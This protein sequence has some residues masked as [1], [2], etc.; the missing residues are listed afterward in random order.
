M[1]LKKAYDKIIGV[2][3]KLLTKF[4]IEENIS[5]FEFLFQNLN[6]KPNLALLGQSGA[7]KSTLLNKII[8]D[9]ILESS[10]GKG[11]VTQYP[12]E[13]KYGS[14]VNYD[15]IPNENIEKDQ[16]K[17]IFEDK[18]YCSTYSDDLL[19]DI[20]LLKK[21]YDFIEVIKGC[22]VPY[23]SKKNKYKW[24]EFNKKI[25]GNENKKYHFQYERE[26]NNIWINV[27]PF[28]NKLIIYIPRE[29]LKKVNLVDLPGSY[30]KSKLRTDKTNDYLENETDFIIIV[31]NNNRAMTSSFIDKSLNNHIA[32]I[33]VSKGIPDILLA[34]T[35]IDY[36]YD[37]IVK[38]YKG[39]QSDSD[40][41]LEDEIY[42][43]IKNELENRMT[44]TSDK[45]E[46]DIKN[47][48]SLEIH[49]IK[50]ENINI[51][52]CSSEKKINDSKNGIGMETIKILS[53]YII[54][55]CDRR[56]NR[57]EN[58]IKYLLD[59]YYTD[60]KNYVNKSNLENEEK[61]KI[62]KIIKN[63]NKEL[64]ESLILSSL[65]ISN[66]ITDTDFNKVIEYNEKYR[67][68]LNDNTHGITLTSVLKKMYH[69][70]IHGEIFNLVEDLSVEYKKEWYNI[71]TDYIGKLEQNH[72]KNKQNLKLVKSFSSL[73]DINGVEKNDIDTLIHKI[74]NSLP[75]GII[76][77]FIFNKQISYEQYLQIEGNNIIHKNIKSVV[78]DYSFKARRVSGNGTSKI[79]RQYIE[80]MLDFDN[81]KKIK[82][83]IDK[84]LVEL[85]LKVNEKINEDFIKILI[86]IFN[87]FSKQYEENKINV[88]NINYILLELKSLINSL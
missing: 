21:I 69:E 27:S 9:N 67:K 7:G 38:E 71:Y 77:N 36:T 11:A 55:I 83:Q 8:G 60:I 88:D 2:N 28:I 15:I 16:L 24:K 42:K 57:Y 41:E 53:D 64:I 65:K 87:T 22:G 48:K 12:I 3:D 50:S 4:L 34:I 31:E 37:S 14:E 46:E 81:S 70:S 5:E 86:Y 30:D 19:T 80:E 59:K 62:K 33:M 56:V 35:Q 54:T 40:E 66:L 47:N 58:N 1:V 82:I 23:D 45:L 78:F 73:N 76:E 52:F 13:I 20:N 85:L 17:E 10:N 61:E 18:N 72:D 75:R 6:K 32:N 44:A 39:D 63:I 51:I 25:N 84:E 29:L 68:R 43:E 49:N 74:E 26:S 79:C